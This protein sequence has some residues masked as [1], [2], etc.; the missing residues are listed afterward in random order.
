MDQAIVYKN[1]LNKIERKIAD[2]AS[3]G[4]DMSSFIK[5][6]ESIVSESLNNTAKSYN[7]KASGIGQSAFLTQ[8]Y[9]ASIKKLRD[10]ESKLEEYDIYYK[11]SSF[12]KALRLFL[13]K[14]E[15]TIEQFNTLRNILLTNIKGINN[16]NTLDYNVEGPIIE[17]IFQMAY[18]FIK[19]EI[20]YFGKSET[21]DKLKVNEDNL[22]FLDKEVRKDL[23]TINLSDAKNSHILEIKSTLE[24]NSQSYFDATLIGAIVDA[25]VNLEQ[26]LNTLKELDIK[27]QKCLERINELEKKLVL[28]SDKDNSRDI[29][30]Q[31]KSL[32]KHLAIFVTSVSI[33]ISLGAITSVISKKLSTKTKYATTTT[34]Y[35][36][37]LDDPYILSN[38]YTTNENNKVTL[39]EYAPFHKDIRDDYTR[40]YYKADLTNVGDLTFEEYLALDL[41]TLGIDMEKYTETKEELSLN[42]LYTENYKVIEKIVVDKNDKIEEFNKDDRIAGLA[43]FGLVSIFTYVAYC[44]TFLEIG[45][46][47]FP[48]IKDDLNE[49]RYHKMTHQEYVQQRD[50]LIKEIKATL[51]ENDEISIKL[52][53]LK[54]Y[55]KEQNAGKDTIK[56]IEKN[57]TLARKIARK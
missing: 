23:E 40:D 19:E 6:K 26:R 25:S 10:L 14:E 57:L 51:N 17:D 20:A 46:D 48:N 3:I 55:C 5:A 30:K 34:L 7:Y 29:K 52:E 18:L 54:P 56:N 49:L 28:L 45:I 12:T 2:Y 50:E 53:N 21:I 38:E 1:E 33:A 31:R 11:T 43:I 15:K 22:Y 44:S 47:P 42:D 16:S 37:E 27:S 32:F 39:Y 41:K 24:Y 35:N 36:P 13:T 9:L 8:D 4:L